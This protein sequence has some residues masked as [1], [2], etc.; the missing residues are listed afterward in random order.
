MMKLSLGTAQFGLDYGVTNTG[1]KVD[2]DLVGQILDLAKSSGITMID[3]AIAYGDSEKVLGQFDL[4]DFSV[5]SK[6]PSLKGAEDVIEEMT[7]DSKERLNIDVLYGL[8]LHDE[9]DA[10]HR[11]GQYL[12]ELQAVKAQGLVQKVGASFYSTDIALDVVKS[13]LVDIIQVPANQLDCRFDE[14]GLLAAAAENNVEVHVRSLLLQG[15]LAVDA[16]KRPAKFRHHSD[17]LKYDECCREMKLSPVEMAL[18]YLVTQPNIHYGVIGCVHPEQLD[19]IIT[20]YKKIE[21]MGLHSNLTLSSHD[22]VL[23]NPSK[24]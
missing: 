17:L 1:G 16:A 21:N 24:W 15:L 8:M 20:A 2:I 3:T 19:E 11:N 14:S 12:E 7:H 18:S 10:I 22:D 5:T 23:V 13:G 6:I 4:S 9:K